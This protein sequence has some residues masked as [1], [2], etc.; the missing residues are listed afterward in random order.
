M[1]ASL[2]AKKSPSE[3]FM[4]F[5]PVVFGSA[6]FLMLACESPKNEPAKPVPEQNVAKTAAPTTAAATAPA[7]PNTAIAPP[8]TSS[9]AQAGG[10]KTGAPLFEGAFPETDS[11]PPA[12]KEWQKDAKV[13]IVKYSSGLL[14]ET[15]AL[16]EWIRVSCRGKPG[17]PNQPTGLKVAKAPKKGQHYELT[18][19]GVTSLVLQP[20]KGQTSE[21]TFEWSNWG[22][23]TLTV[24]FPENSEKPEI[25]FDKAAP[26]GK[27]GLPRCEDVCSTMPIHHNY[28]SD[29]AYPCGEGYKCEW[30]DS[31]DER[32]AMCVCATECSD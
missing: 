26:A 31:G 16:R 18:R 24:S 27:T 13:Y 10:T 30:W 8:A 4:K 7:A 22:A 19:E 15:L 32:T 29:C 6:M 2:S 9:S 21:Y 11:K 23:R 3:R 5:A 20:R 17:A 25:A 28:M 12:V 14:C 1:P